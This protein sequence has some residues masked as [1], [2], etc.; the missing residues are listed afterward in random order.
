VIKRALIFLS[1]VLVVFLAQ[2]ILL[3][4]I[5]DEYQEWVPYA[6]ITGIVNLILQ[7]TGSAALVLVKNQQLAT[8][9]MVIS[10]FCITSTRV[11]LFSK[12]RQTEEN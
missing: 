2:G 10:F 8:F 5:N 7:A 4:A 12:F 1:F 9:L 3:F 6:Y 11:M